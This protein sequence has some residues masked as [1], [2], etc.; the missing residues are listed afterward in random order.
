MICVEKNTQ[1][2]VFLF[3]FVCLLAC[4]CV[5]VIHLLSI[6]KY[7]L[8]KS[9]QIVKS[10]QVGICV[11]SLS[12]R[13]IFKAGKKKSC[14]LVIPSNNATPLCAMTEIKDLLAGYKLWMSTHPP[15][16]A[17]FIFTETSHGH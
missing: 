9:F 11:K 13:S 10:Q 7:T 14:I 8:T 3:L 2:C 17:E 5:Y 15:E 1:E 6:Q 4:L 12:L 16:K